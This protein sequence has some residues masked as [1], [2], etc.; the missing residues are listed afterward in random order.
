MIT[1]RP[2]SDRR[3][4]L[5]FR[6]QGADGK[7]FYLNSCDGFTQ[8]KASAKIFPGEQDWRPVVSVDPVGWE[9]DTVSHGEI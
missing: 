2:S 3:R 5:Y 4:V 8:E 7:K 1:K 9:P 6:P